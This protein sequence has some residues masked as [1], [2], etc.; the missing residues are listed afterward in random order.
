MSTNG[1]LKYGL[2]PT[3]RLAENISPFA[4]IFTLKQDD[5]DAHAKAIADLIGTDEFAEAVSRMALIHVFSMSRV[6]RNQLFFQTNFDSD[7]VSYFEAFKDLDGPLREI[8]SHFENAPGKDAE[9]TELL[10][11]IAA[12]Q[13]DVIAYFC[14]YPELTVNQIRRD[15][16][17]RI[18]IVEL[19]KSLAHPAEKVAWGQTASALA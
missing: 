18:K 16:D 12:Q 6:G 3:V 1:T 11:F 17:W 19:Q 5:P 10:E 15:A 14:A 7:V 8:L 4:A 2:R 13:V 9:F